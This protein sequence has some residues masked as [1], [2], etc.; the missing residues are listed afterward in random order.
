MRAVVT[1]GSGFIG[2]WVC[3]DLLNSGYEVVCVDNFL[4]SGRNNIS[5]FFENDKFTFIEADITDSP[6]IRGGVDFVLHLASPASPIDYQKIPVET[7][8]VNSQG[9]YN[10]LKLARKN[11]ARFILASTSEVYGDPTQHP[12]N[13]EYW[14]NV[15]PIGVRSCYDEGKRFAESLT[16]TF[17]RTYKTN[18]GIVRIFNTYGPRMRAGD[19]RVIPSFVKQALLGEEIKVSG[20]GSQTRSFCYISD[21]VMGIKTLMLSPEAGPV[22]LGNPAEISILELAKKIKLL[23]GSTSEISFVPLPEDDPYRR[24]PDI[25]RAIKLGWSPKVELDE[26]LKY[27][28]EW[29]QKVI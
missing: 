17:R 25:S 2:T 27:T 28:I 21:M 16:M 11:N 6:D 20:N 14:G 26:G 1:G 7:M 22:N 3:E 5:Q 18:T 15:N 19:G 10:M 9:T 13:E 29:F 4:T 24:K 8:L 23:T 12:Q